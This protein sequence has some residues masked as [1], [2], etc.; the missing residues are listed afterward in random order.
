MTAFQIIGYL[1]GATYLFYCMWWGTYQ[2][3]RYYNN[4]FLTKSIIVNSVVAIFFAII[5]LTVS[6]SVKSAG[7]LIPISFIV[8]L[9]IL[10][11]FSM[12]VNKRHFYSIRKHESMP[13][14]GN[15]LDIILTVLTLF[16]SMTLPAI[17][18]NI[19]INGR[20]FD[21]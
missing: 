12:V 1:I 2:N 6:F 13:Y 15:A 11:I 9:R 7:Y 10:D 21:R 4:L 3:E 18:L 17:I 8:T 5:G 16:I 14:G 20:V 19:Y